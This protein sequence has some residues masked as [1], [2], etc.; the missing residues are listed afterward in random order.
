[1]F[2]WSLKPHFHQEEYLFK[3]LKNNCNR[4]RDIETVNLKKSWEG[5]KVDSKVRNLKTLL[6]SRTVR[7]YKI[8]RRKAQIKTQ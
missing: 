1:M 8:S 7:E 4:E 2:C 5:K 3:R 6:P